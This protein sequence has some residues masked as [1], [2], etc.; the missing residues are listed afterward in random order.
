MALTDPGCARRHAAIQHVIRRAE[1]GT[2]QR[3][4]W[5]LISSRAV[6]RRAVRES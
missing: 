2:I 3:A 5:H 4:E 1:D 6:T